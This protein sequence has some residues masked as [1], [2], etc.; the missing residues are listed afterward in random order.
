MIDYSPGRIKRSVEDMTDDE[1]NKRFSREEIQNNM[2]FWTGHMLATGLEDLPATEGSGARAKPAAAAPL[3]RRK[4][5]RDSSSFCIVPTL[6][7][8]LV[9][10]SRN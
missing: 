6:L 3:V 4:R 5:R 9:P 1:K 8:L 7:F 2:I 10:F